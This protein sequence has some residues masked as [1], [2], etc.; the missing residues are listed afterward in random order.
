MFGSKLFKAAISIG[1]L[2]NIARSL[3]C[4]PRPAG[5]LVENTG[6]D[7]ESTI[8]AWDWRNASVVNAPTYPAH[9]GSRS[10]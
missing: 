10:L 7:D 3:E 5:E 2:A 8:W 6:F 1:V 4:A 9:S